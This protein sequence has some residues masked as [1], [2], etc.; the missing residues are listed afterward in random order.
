METTLNNNGFNRPKTFKIFLFVLIGIVLLGLLYWLF[1]SR[2]SES[3]DDAYVA[4]SQIQVVS[5]IEGAIATVNVSE[6]Q[7]V[8]EG[9]SLFRIDPTE[10]MIA[11][12]KADIDLRNADSDY[13]KRK[14]LQGD[15][16]VSKEELE[17]SQLALLK[18]IANARQAYINLL[19]VDVQS[20]VKATMA[21]RYA[22]VGQ[23][24]APGTQLALMVAGDQIWVDANFKE[25]QLKHIRIGQPVRLESDIY[26]G[27]MDFH[28]K[29]VG[30][31]PGTGSTLALLP[32]Q[33][34]TGN[35]VKVVQRLP[36]RI[37]LDTEELNK[38]PLNIGLSMNVKVDT[39]NREGSALQAM[40]K[41]P[42]SDTTIYQKQFDKA[43]RHI[44]TLLIKSKKL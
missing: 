20:P 42:I 17:H 4:G 14:A 28:G 13:Q 29:V 33:N 12:E 38:Y 36:V 31:A 44:Q 9:Q 8:E 34:A 16:S 2:N 37:S 19:R 24:V 6:T 15:A 27:K 32:P 30:F 25:D 26:G 3:T 41:G 39:S 35:W 21:K 1:F 11:S 5:Q 22:Q 43:E 18:A 7:A 23:R 10:V 40:E